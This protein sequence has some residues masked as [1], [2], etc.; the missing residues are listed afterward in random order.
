MNNP[1][2]KST[3]GDRRH[4]QILASYGLSGMD[5]PLDK[6][7]EGGKCPR[8]E[9]IQAEGEQQ[10][11]TTSE[12]DGAA[13]T[14]EAA[15][16]QGRGETEGMPD[17]SGR[18]SRLSPDFPH[19]PNMSTSWGLFSFT[20]R[21][22]RGTYLATVIITSIVIVPIELVVV[23]AAGYPETPEAVDVATGFIAIPAIWIFL[24]THVKRWHDLGYFG[25]IVALAFIPVVNAV[26]FLAAL[27]CLV[28]IKGTTGPN[29]YGADPLENSY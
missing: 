28:F 2:G 1:S 16:N 23:F 6:S 20:G 11:Y 8:E 26:Y 27:V 21:I 18:A 5:N 7:D 19:A 22:G 29:K 17:S 15:P 3:E 4:S 9:L 14:P 24:A 13:L 25:W 10:S 12:G